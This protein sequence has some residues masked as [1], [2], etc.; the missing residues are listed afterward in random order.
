MVTATAAGTGE[1]VRVAGLG[2]VLLGTVVAAT[3]ASGRTATPGA[4]VTSA[5]AREARPG[6]M[7]VAHS[8]LCGTWALVTCGSTPQGGP[9]CAATSRSRH[10]RARRPVCRGLQPPAQQHP[11]RPGL[12]AAPDPPPH[13]VLPGP[14][15]SGPSQGSSG[16]SVLSKEPTGDRLVLCFNPL[17]QL[18]LR[19]KGVPPAQ[20][21]PLQGHRAIRAA[22]P[23]HLLLGQQSAG[24]SQT[25]ALGPPAHPVLLTWGLARASGGPPGR[26]PC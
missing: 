7:L 20:N 18:P 26:D 8:A 5:D 17:P 11:S 10:A 6:G 15:H 13:R 23:V 12:P 21:W 16:G 9:G 3:A 24:D 22:G 25:W 2:P 4:E 14:G 1:M 19:S